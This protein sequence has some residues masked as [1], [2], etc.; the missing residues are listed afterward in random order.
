MQKMMSEHQLLQV[1]LTNL[2]SLITVIE[3][4]PAA[5]AIEQI[6]LYTSQLADFTNVS[7]VQSK[8]SK[9]RRILKKNATDIEKSIG[10]VTLAFKEMKS[11]I[12]WRQRAEEK[13][14]PELAIYDDAIRMTIGMR[15]QKRLTP[16]QANSVASCLAVHR[17]ISLHF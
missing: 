6:K 3:N 11:E 4:Q 9:A 8:L 15:L 10:K 1:N 16:N 7:S 17:D 14:M 12:D 2:E 5:Q 13:L